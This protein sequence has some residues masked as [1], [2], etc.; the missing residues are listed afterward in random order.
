MQNQLK[1]AH[2]PYLL[3]HAQNPVFWQMWNTQNRNFAK[4]SNKLLIISIGYAACHWCHV[5]EKECFEDNEVAHVMNASFTSFKIDREELP[6]IDAY[7]MQ[8][9]Q[10]MTKQGGWPL[11]IVA[12]PNG[13]P[14]WGATYVPKAQW[15]D[16]LEQLAELFASNP[17]KMYE[18]AEKLQNGISLANNMLEIYP[19][20]STQFDFNPLLSNW[21]KSF[22]D[23]FGGYQRAP[24][25][26]MPTNLNFLYQYG[27]ATNDASLTQHVELTLSKMAYGGLFDV[28]EGGFSRYSV[29][30]KW[31]IPHFE[32]M[33]YDNAQLLTTYSKAYLRT[34]NTLYKNV[35]EKTVAFVTKNW[36]DASGGF[37][38]AYDADS[39]NTENK[40]QEGAYYFWQKNELQ[41]L[42]DPSEW[43]LFADVFSINTDGFWEEAQAYVLFQKED[44]AVIAKKYHLNLNHL[45]QLKMN[46]EQ[47]LLKNREKRTKPLLDDKIITSWNAQL[48]TGL[49]MAERIIPSQKINQSIAS[50][51]HFLQ[52]KAFQNNQLGRVF[53][54]NKLYIDGT[55]EDYAFTIEAFIQ[56]FNKTQQQ[57][58]LQFAQELTFYA[59][60]VFFDE[61]QG[62]FKASKDN[63]LGTVFEIEDN[64]IPSGNAIMARNLFY[65]GFLFKNE[66]F[67]KVS[68]EMIERVLAQIN[69]ASAY[70]EWLTNYLLVT[71][72]FEYIILKDV[73]QEEFR[74]IYE[75]NKHQIILNNS[76]N[77]PILD[78]YK[79]QTKKFQVC[80]LHSCQIET[81]DFTKILN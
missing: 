81:N 28:L 26:M 51:T 44:L 2:S 72:H 10:L 76:L 19:K 23:E 20:Q 53:K 60:D 30:H 4:E 36:Q 57:Q 75:A 68:N 21:K 17:E 38:A 34:N 48:L 64:V 13:L 42:I 39:F 69:Y 79:N 31:H 67:T 7:Y 41:D 16:V 12:L 71:N 65:L 27:I 47:L 6:A 33:L 78:G 29:D 5:M 35:V 54:N 59:L 24:K 22:D 14:V 73:S 77:I 66:Y 25:F 55:L 61:K 63:S 15:I 37:Y 46:W 11:N 32:K 74:A 50:L 8:A 56:L 70:S 3:Q 18:Y 80:T 62:F 40:L 1:N 49:L 43:N 58:H 52:T 45:E 9:L